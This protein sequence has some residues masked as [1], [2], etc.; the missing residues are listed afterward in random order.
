MNLLI[1]LGQCLMLLL[2]IGYVA[3]IAVVSMFVVSSWLDPEV[4]NSLALAAFSTTPILMLLLLIPVF[5]WLRRVGRADR[6]LAA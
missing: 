2:L 3:L 4:V 5:R 1:A 6:V